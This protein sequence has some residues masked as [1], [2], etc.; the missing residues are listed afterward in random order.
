MP[1]CT[2]RRTYA[3]LALQGLAQAAERRDLHLARQ[4]RPAARH[5]APH[6]Q[7]SQVLGLQGRLRLHCTEALLSTLNKIF[8][9]QPLLNSVVCP[10]LF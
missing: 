8:C 4:Q 9:K 7:R 2:G 6:H 3:P 1:I 5:V 10:N